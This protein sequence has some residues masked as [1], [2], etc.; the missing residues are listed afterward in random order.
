[1]AI[2]VDNL[3]DRIRTTL[4][5]IDTDTDKQRWSDA[6]LIDYLNEGAKV[7]VLNKTDANTLFTTM[8]LSSGTEQSLPSG[9]LQLIDVVCNM[10]TNGTTPGRTA[11]IIDK[12]KMDTSTPTWHSDT[13]AT[14]VKN[15]VYDKNQMDKFY[16]YPKSDGTNYIRLIYAAV[17][18]VVAAG[19]NISINDKYETAL[20]DWIL[21]RAYLKDA[22]F[23]P[24]ASQ[25]S[26]KYFESFNTTLGLQVRMETINDD[27]KEIEA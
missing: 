9:A 7:V 18:T 19:E 23:S 10:G 4:Q 2:A 24:T 25:M 6:E 26:N 15:I 8:Q 14:A 27:Y 16:V 13:A 11:P 3:V 1:M 20:F 17:P 5:D 21:F 12:R 22:D